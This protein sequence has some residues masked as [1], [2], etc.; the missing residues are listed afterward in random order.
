[1]RNVIKINDF[2][3]FYKDVDAVP[4][5]TEGAEEISLPHT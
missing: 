1:M 3:L 2:W 4:V 5:E